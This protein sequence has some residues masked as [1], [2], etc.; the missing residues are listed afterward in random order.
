[1]CKECLID[2]SESQEEAKMFH[3][4]WLI[5]LMVVVVWKEPEDSSFPYFKVDICEVAGYASL[6]FTKES[7]HAI[8]Y[9]FLF[10]DVNGTTHGGELGSKVFT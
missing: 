1:M 7:M 5:I 10:V 6:W 2:C 4:A 9:S 8:E 3:Y